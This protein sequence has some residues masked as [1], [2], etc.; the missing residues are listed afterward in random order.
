MRERDG[1]R[2]ELL[3]AAVAEGLGG[4][5]LEQ[6]RL[7]GDLHGRDRDAV[8]LLE[9]LDGVD[10]GVADVEVEGQRVEAGRR[11]DV[12]AAPRLRPDRRQARHAE[13]GEVEVGR[14]SGRRS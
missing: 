10:R 11:L 5:H 1:E 6:D 3:V 9:V 4:R 13:A 12:V 7:H 14:R 2:V 8:L